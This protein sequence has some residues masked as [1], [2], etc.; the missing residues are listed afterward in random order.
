M[1][2]KKVLSCSVLK[3]GESNLESLKFWVFEEIVSGGRGFCYSDTDSNGIC[4]LLADFPVTMFFPK[5]AS[6]LGRGLAFILKVISPLNKVK[7]LS[8]LFKCLQA[9]IILHIFM[10]KLSVNKQ[11]VE[12]LL[13]RKAL[14]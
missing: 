13:E 6:V 8:I 2:I 3:E 10:K 12:V 5:I 1:A 9:I 4:F 14:L 11:V 7:T